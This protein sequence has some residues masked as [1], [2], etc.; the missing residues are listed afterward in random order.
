MGWLALGHYYANQPG[1][2]PSSRGLLRDYEPSYGLFWSTSRRCW[3]WCGMVCGGCSLGHG[4]LEEIMRMPCTAL[5]ERDNIQPTLTF[6]KDSLCVSSTFYRHSLW[7]RC[8]ACLCFALCCCILFVY[9]RSVSTSDSIANNWPFWLRCRYLLMW[10]GARIQVIV[11]WQK[12]KWIFASFVS[13]TF[14]TVTS[15]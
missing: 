14:K 7:A 8:I 15:A 10:A 13:F 9:F 11:G 4:K 5:G 2:G 1:E 3:C 12:Q 6:H